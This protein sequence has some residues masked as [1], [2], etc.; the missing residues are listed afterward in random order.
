MILD[1][2][3]WIAY[4]YT[5]DALHTQ[6]VRLIENSTDYP[7]IIFEYNLLEAV[8]VLARL[9]G[10]AKAND[11]LDLILNTDG[12]EILPSSPELFEAVVVCY[13]AHTQRTLSFADYALLHLSRTIPVA[14]FDSKLKNAI[15]RDKGKYYA[16]AV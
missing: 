6:A 9:T 14:T 16:S 3:I 11:F 5:D 2:N 15:K 1:S 10:K 13:K 8:T 7:S 4:V 12:I